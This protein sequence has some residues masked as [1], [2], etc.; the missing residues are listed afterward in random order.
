M[1]RVE[2]HAPEHRHEP[3]PEFLRRLWIILHADGLPHRGSCNRISK[4]EKSSHEHAIP[5][6]LSSDNDRGPPADSRFNRV[7]DHLQHSPTTNG[8]TRWSRQNQPGQQSAM[9]A[10]RE[11]LGHPFHHTFGRRITLGVPKCLDEI[12]L[13]VLEPHP[14][15]SIHEPSTRTKVVQNRRMGDSEFCGDLLQAKSIGA[16]LQ[17]MPFGDLQNPL[18]SFVSTASS[19]TSWCLVSH[20]VSCRGRGR[21]GGM[22]YQASV[23]VK[24][25]ASRV[26]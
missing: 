5:N 18:P 20:L 16:H 24:N 21:E 22:G 25:F 19:T 10:G 6:L 7:G 11:H 17:K 26:S 13:E 4:E 14:H 12:L 23:P 1:G 3:P 8:L 9:A 15:D 2:D